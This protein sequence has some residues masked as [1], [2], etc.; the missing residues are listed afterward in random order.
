MLYVI[1]S[2]ADNKWIGSLLICFYL[3]IYIFSH[4]CNHFSSKIFEMLG[5]FKSLQWLNL[6]GLDI[7]TDGALQTVSSI[8]III[9][10]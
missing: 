10:V 2:S 9:F 8:I 6:Y 1:A 4:R 7:L 5:N 3:S